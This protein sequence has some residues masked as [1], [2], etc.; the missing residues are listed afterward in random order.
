[1][2]FALI[3]NSG[4]V[5]HISSPGVNGMLEHGKTYDNLLCVKLA[6][7]VDISTFAATNWYDKTES[8]EAE[9][10]KTMSAQPDENHVFSNGLWIFDKSKLEA[11]V[12]LDR[13]TLLYQS[14]WTQV[15]DSALSDSKK[16]E[17]ATYRQKL[18]DFP[19][20]IPDDVTLM[21]Q[22]TWPTKPS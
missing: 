12:R 22:L 7:S 2:K 16:E 20:T 4:Q 17:W 18:R 14:D 19:S 3:A 13:T 1:M 5:A 11:A 21:S 6:D 9:R 10:W 8:D 15:V